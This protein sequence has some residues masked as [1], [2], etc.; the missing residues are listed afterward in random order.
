MK[1]NNSTFSTKWSK[2]LTLLTRGIFSWVLRQDLHC[3]WI[4]LKNSTYLPRDRDT[5]DN[6]ISSTRLDFSP[7]PY[8]KEG[9]LHTTREVL[10]ELE[11]SI[12]PHFMI[13]DISEGV[14]GLWSVVKVRAFHFFSPVRFPTSKNENNQDICT[15]VNKHDICV[16]N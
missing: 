11:Y 12:P 5:A 16:R 7:G 4:L 2:F 1:G 6:G 10:P 8:F 15:Y 14:S 13:L 9:L 3:W